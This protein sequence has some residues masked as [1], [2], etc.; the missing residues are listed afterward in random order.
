MAQGMFENY[1]EDIALRVDA[2]HSE[3]KRPVVIGMDGMAASGKT[4][5]ASL[6]ANRLDAAVIHMDDFFLPQGFR[7]PERLRTPGG[8]V[9]YE[10]FCKEVKPYIRSGQLF[11]YRVFDAHKHDYV[12]TRDIWP[13]PVILVEGC[14][15]MHP[16]IGDIYDL[17]LF[18]EVSP[19]E[20]EKRIAQTRAAHLE[21]YK[22]MWIPMEN[23]YHKAFRIK[24]LCDMV[25]TSG[26]PQPA[27][28][29]E[30]ERKWL[31]RMPDLAM[32][33]AKA[34][35]VIEM[36][37]VYLKGGAPGVSMRVRKSAEGDKVTYH[38]NEKRRLT[39]TV[40]IEREEEIDEQH[41][42]IL[43]GF[44]DP[45]L[46]KIQKTRYCV[47]LDGG[48]IAEIDVFPFWGDRAFCEVELPT[49]DTP[50]TLPHWLDVVRE[51]SDDK[52]YTNLALAREIP[53]EEIV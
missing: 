45:A 8:N 44:A 2:L 38:R 49:V 5:L 48:L 3:D 15:C 12:D 18:V 50:V 1:I 23:R 32:L 14:Y 29:L 41:Y 43:L 53:V 6:L 28:P 51:V 17:R 40:R 30:I 24:E 33:R 20:Q 35:R 37:Q 26:E 10:R 31:L 11:G 25:I 9:Y 52:R 34:E 46:R 36:E 27:P 4:T 22:A 39:D 47:A 42:K 13:K 16:E 19:Y 21:M 7:T